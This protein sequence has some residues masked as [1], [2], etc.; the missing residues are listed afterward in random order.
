MQADPDRDFGDDSRARSC[1]I[2]LFTVHI[3]LP[4]DRLLFDCS[5]WSGKRV[6]FW[7]TNRLSDQMVHELRKHAGAFSRRRVS[8]QSQNTVMGAVAGEKS[9]EL[10]EMHDETAVHSDHFVQQAKVIHSRET[11]RESQ[12]RTTQNQVDLA[13]KSGALCERIAVARSDTSL[14][15]RFQREGADIAALDLNE[16]A[17]RS[18]LDRLGLVYK[19]ALWGSTAFPNWALTGSLRQERMN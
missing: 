17:L 6:L 14:Y 16:A 7:M 2:H 12:L 10:G 15:L 3:D 18:L 13:R 19:C 8:M 5:L 1:W 4:E 9:G 11:R